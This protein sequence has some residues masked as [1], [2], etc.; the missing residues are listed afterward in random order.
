MTTAELAAIDGLVDALFEPGYAIVP[1]FLSPE[2]IRAM[3]EDCLSRWQSG[4]F[5]AAGIG[6]AQD[7]R[8]QT[9]IRSDHVLWLDESAAVPAQADYWQLMQTYQQSINRQLYLGLQELEAHFAVYP[10]GSFYR[11]HLDR[12]RDEDART[13]TVIVYLNDDW[14]AAD[15]GYLRLYRDAAGESD[16]LDVAPE[17]GTLVTFLSDRFWHEVLPAHRER[18]AVTGW[19]RRRV[20]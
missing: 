7:Q 13:V 9:E 16:V 17:A 12:F 1:G 5:H 18:M 20:A 8:V 14:Q 6:R 11:K 19:F 15:G 2:T 4:Q 3:R 10:P